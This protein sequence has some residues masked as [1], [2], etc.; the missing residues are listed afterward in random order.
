MKMSFEPRP[1]RRVVTGN[2]EQGRSCVL[3]DSAAGNVNP[4]G[5]SCM[6]D[7]WV[8]DRTPAPIAGRRDDGDLPFNFEPPPHGG[9]LRIVESKGRPADYD[10]A[11][12]TQAKARHETV[13]SPAGTLYRGG[14]NAFSSPYHKS[15]TID[16]GIVL[17]GK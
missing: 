8:Y 3:Y 11:T 4:R 2:D 12:D 5:S 7:L 1:I 13:R 9:H 15:E 10:P 17:E 16:Y 14:Q 6:T